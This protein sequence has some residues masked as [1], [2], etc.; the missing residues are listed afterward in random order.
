MFL[1]GLL[2][3]TEPVLITRAPF[4][5]AILKARLAWLPFCCLVIIALCMYNQLCAIWRQSRGTVTFLGY[6]E[7]SLLENKSNAF[8]RGFRRF[9]STP[10]KVWPTPASGQPL[11]RPR[12]Q[13]YPQTPFHGPFFHYYLLANMPAPTLQENMHIISYTQCS[14]EIVFHWRKVREQVRQAFTGTQ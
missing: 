11:Q 7:T 10:L 3:S 6:I 2:A 9:P 12:A 1:F 13:V 14:L 4:C 8:P 5:S